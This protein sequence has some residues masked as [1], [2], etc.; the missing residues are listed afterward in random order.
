MTIDIREQG[1]VLR[2]SDLMKKELPR[3]TRKLDIP[4][5]TVTTEL[6]SMIT[7]I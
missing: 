7:W 1:F 6:W 2:V 3:P 5:I 4:I